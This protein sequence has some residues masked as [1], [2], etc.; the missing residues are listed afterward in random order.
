MESF[1]TLFWLLARFLMAFSLLIGL[2]TLASFSA[3]AADVYSAEVRIDRAVDNAMQARE[4]ALR[5]AQPLALQ[6]LMKRLVFDEDVKR[7]P[8]VSKETFAKI[9]QSV[10]I[11][12]EK[13]SARRYSADITVRFDAHGIRSLLRNSSV[14]Y[15]ETVSKPVLVLPVYDLGDRLVLWDER[16]SW[17]DAWGSMP[18]NEGLVPLITPVG[19]LA[20]VSDIKGDQS[21]IKDPVRLARISVRYGAGDILVAYAAPRKGKDGRPVVSVTV[22]RFGDQRETGIFKKT[23]IGESMP[24]LPAVL[25][26]V[27]EQVM[28]G[29][30]KQWK[31]KNLIAYRYRNTIP[32]RILIE[33]LRDWVGVRKRLDDTPLVRGYNVITLTRGLAEVELFFE[34]STDQLRLALAQKDLLL[35][36]GGRDTWTVRLSDRALEALE[37]GVGHREGIV[38]KE[39][40]LPSATPVPARGQGPVEGGVGQ[41]MPKAYFAPGAQPVPN[42]SSVPTPPQPE[43]P[44]P[45]GE[46]WPKGPEQG[47][48]ERG[49]PDEPKNAPNPQLAPTGG[50]AN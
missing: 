5:D 28:A 32:V 1:Q 17:L 36:P 37:V 49:G 31:E 29:L 12:N 35:Q 26:Q 14:R 45:D 4:Q 3:A 46:Q 50:P 30:E 10:D 7:V 23:Y 18:Q 21:I 24:K 8:E 22:D 41:D 42:R 25:R 47:G 15:A 38:E 48:Q 19:D 34:G 16:N 2:S 33:E 40:G 39:P 20:D 11:S 44:I 9:I 13:V 43:A 27:S 6:K